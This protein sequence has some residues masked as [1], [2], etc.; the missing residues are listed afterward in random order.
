MLQINEPY[1][2]YLINTFN[3]AVYFKVHARDPM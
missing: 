1:H 3:V 2:S